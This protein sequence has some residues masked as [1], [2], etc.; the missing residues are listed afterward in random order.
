MRLLF[1]PAVTK[2]DK[3]KERLAKEAAAR[4][5]TPEEEIMDSQEAYNDAKRADDLGPLT[6][7]S[8]S[9]C[10]LYRVR[11]VRVADRKVGHVVMLP[12]W[13]VRGKGARPLATT[14]VPPV[15]C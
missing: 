12:P 15:C 14:Q 2:K 7:K 13:V 3:E 9:P 8:L 10:T 5:K 6:P 1:A 11:G 4:P